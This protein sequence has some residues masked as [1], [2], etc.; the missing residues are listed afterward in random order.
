[1][2]SINNLTAQDTISAGDQFVVY[3][4]GNGDTRRISASALATYLQ[5]QISSSGFQIQ[6]AAPS[7]TGQTTIVSPL[8]QGA[9]TWLQ[10]AP[11]GAYAAGTI[12]FPA[13]TVSVD[14]Q[15]ILVTTTQAVTALTSNYLNASG[16]SVA[17]VGAPTTLAA[18]SFFRLRFDPVF[19]LWVRVG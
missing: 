3:S 15:E 6:Y 2:T 7:A 17:V 14:G 11:L 19:K 10:M 8:V 1:M 16:V 5:S 13:A 4:N 9:S 12:T 18:N